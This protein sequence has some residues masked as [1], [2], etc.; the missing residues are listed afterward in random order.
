MTPKE[1]AKKITTQYWSLLT[2]WKMAIIAVRFEEL[3]EAQK[4]DSNFKQ[5]KQCALIAVDQI[6]NIEGNYL[7]QR[8]YWQ[9]VKTAIENL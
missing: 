9:Q 4:E 6:L 3:A 5:A 8:D 7:I 1:K 2:G